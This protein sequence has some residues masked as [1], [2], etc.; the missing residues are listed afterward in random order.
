[1]AVKK[2]TKKRKDTI[3]IPGETVIYQSNRIT[4]GKFKG[5]TLLQA[6]IL[7]CLIKNLQ[8]EIKADMAGKDWKQGT[9]FEDVKGMLRIGLNLSEISKPDQ[10]HQVYAAAEELQKVSVELKSPNEGYIRI[11][12]LI[13]MLDVPKI[14][15]KYVSPKVKG[16]AVMYVSILRE[17]AEKLIEVEKNINGQP[18][19]FTKY[20]YEV[21]MASRNKYTW[22]L[23]TIISSWKQK[24]GF[25]IKLNEL[26][27]QL[28]LDST[29]YTEY[30]DFKRRVLRPVQKELEGKADCWFNCAEKSFEIRD[31]KTVTRLNF[32]VIVPEMEDELKIKIENIKTLLR[33]HMG[34][35]NSHISRIEGFLSSKLTKERV[36]AVYF[37]I[38]EINEYITTKKNTVEPVQNIA[39]Y[40]LKSLLD[41]GI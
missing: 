39:T 10:Y 23:Y 29:E 17:V 21:A 3:I 5:F 6:K 18:Q 34:F 19:F 15:D 32:K 28:G 8:K 11:A 41:S 13:P 2:I 7:L 4:H 22:K 24:G 9:L 30:S 26:R 1:M 14:R 40:T 38:T 35:K 27:E 16:K 36:D 20:L 33:I 37:K 25:T 12:S 31:N